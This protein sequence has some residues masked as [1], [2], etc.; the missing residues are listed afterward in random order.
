MEKEIQIRKMQKNDLHQIQTLYRELVPEGVSWETISKN[1]ESTG[2][3]ANYFHAV[4]ESGGRILGSAIGI[5]CTVP[6]ASFL[7][8]ENVVIDKAYRGQGIGRELMHALDRFAQ[9]H[10]CLYAILVSSGFRT[11]AHHFYEAMGYT[12]CVQGFRKYYDIHFAP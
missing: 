8:V 1:F 12:D 10:N 2:T 9:S 7:V 6:D 3:A 4:A 11:E 5:V